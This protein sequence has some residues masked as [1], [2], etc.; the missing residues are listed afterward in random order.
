MIGA[1]SVDRTRLV[2]ASLLALLALGLVGCGAP[3]LCTPE[4]DPDDL[5]CGAGRQDLLSAHQRV[6]QR[7]PDLLDAKLVRVQSGMTGTLNVDGL[8]ER[9][10]LMFIESGG[11]GAQ[12]TVMGDTLDRRP[13]STEAVCGEITPLDVAD[14][15]AA[16]QNAVERFES[17]FRTVHL[18]QEINLFFVDEHECFRT[19]VPGARYVRILETTEGGSMLHFFYHLGSDDSIARVCGPCDSADANLCTACL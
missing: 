11:L 12:V 16:V 6:T 10:Q 5:F 15:R 7:Y 9:W 3:S 13:A 17:D 4:R 8:D 1:A 2:R 19:A 18:G 14:T